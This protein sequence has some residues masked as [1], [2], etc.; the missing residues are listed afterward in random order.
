MAAAEAQ[1]II[2]RVVPGSVAAAI[3]L[4]PGDALVAIDGAPVTDLVDY[5]FRSDEEYLEL[6]VTKASGEQWLIEV[7]KDPGEDLGLEFADATFDGIYTCHNRCVFCFVHQMPRRRGLR[8]S[9]YLMDDDYRLSFMHGNFITLVGIAAADWQRILSQRLS[10]LYISVHA[11]ADDLRVRLMGTTQ[12]AG[13]MGRLAELAAHDIAFHTQVVACPGWNDGP[14]LEQTLSDLL[15]LRPATLSVSVVPVGLTK[16][17]ERLTLIEPYDAAGAAAV[18]DQVHAW[19][20]RCR[21]RFGSYIVHASD[22]FYVR[23]GRPVPPARRYEGFAQYENGVG[24]IRLFLDELRR[25]QPR[26]P[27]A[28]AAPRRVTVVT[29]MLARATVAEALAALA[30]VAGLTT[31][32]VAVEN[33]FFGPTVTCTGLLTAEDVLAAL[34]GRDL[35]DLVVLPAQMVREGDGQTIDNSSLAAIEAALGVAV[36]T[37]LTARDLLQ[38]CTGVRVGRGRR[39]PRSEPPGWLPAAGCALAGDAGGADRDD[40][41]RLLPGLQRPRPSRG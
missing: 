35:G 13:I 2:S 12:A 40:G 3:G 4:E 11:T 21:R 37:G 1:A 25:L 20:R 38:H 23:A 16:H 9:L 6:A 5:R 14:A 10:P 41:C 27:A 36:A 29:G 22:E 15:S 30:P 33:R 34:A 24:M 39:P 31:E 18:L 32:L 28:L 26:L 17:R 8:R 7:E 19:Q